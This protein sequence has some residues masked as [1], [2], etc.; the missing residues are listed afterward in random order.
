MWGS[1]F[2][3][4]LGI[5]QFFSKKSSSPSFTISL[6]T[7][8]LTAISFLPTPVYI[9]YF[10]LVF[11]LALLSVSLLI[12][13]RLSFPRRPW[14]ACT[15]CLILLSFLVLRYT[16]FRRDVRQFTK[17]GQGVIGIGNTQNA[18]TWR[19]FPVEEFAKKIDS[20]AHSGE[21]VLTSWPGF[22]LST[23]NARVAQGYENHF[24]LYIGDDITRNEREHFLI[25]SW[26]D[27]EMDIRAQKFRLLALENRWIERR[28]LEAIQSAGYTKIARVE[29][30]SLFERPGHTKDTWSPPSA[31]DQK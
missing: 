30:F 6:F 28:M 25:R 26:A 10:C 15:I 3:F 7:L 17:T 31:P 2:A 20:T 12:H 19:V 27:M 24:G 18:R 9:Q 13:E 1:I 21:E 14:Q 11:P 29:G 22:F 8:T 5:L 16:D 4:L 23:R